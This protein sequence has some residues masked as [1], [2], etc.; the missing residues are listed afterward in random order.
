MAYSDNK[1]G[2]N[3]LFLGAIAGIAVIAV[4]VVVNFA[5]Q[6]DEWVVNNINVHAST[7]IGGVKF[8]I[9]GNQEGGSKTRI[10]N[11]SAE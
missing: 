3:R 10:L 1:T 6:R 4:L 5:I 11:M 7:V 2:C 8:E 9:F